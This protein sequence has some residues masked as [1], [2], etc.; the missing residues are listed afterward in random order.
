MAPPADL[1]DLRLERAVA[2][3]HALGPRVFAEMLR[4]IGASTMHMTTIEQVV[5]RYARIDRDALGAV[6]GDRFTPRPLHAVRRE[7]A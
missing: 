7:H 3:L 5:E 2:R 1:R 6:G 4:E